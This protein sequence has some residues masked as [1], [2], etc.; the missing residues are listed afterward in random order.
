MNEPSLIYIVEDSPSA[1]KALVTFL[2]ASGYLTQSHNNGELLLTALEQSQKNASGL[3]DLILMD[4]LLPGI[5]GVELI[6]IIKSDQSLPFIPIIMITSSQVLDDRINSLQTGADDFLT[7]PFNRAELLARVRSL[8]RLKAA[9]DE[10]TRLVAGIKETYEQLRATQKELLKMETTKAQ[11]EAM[12]STAGAICH[13]MSQPLTSALI[14][15]Q[16]MYQDVRDSNQK[17]ELMLIEKCLLEARLILDKLRTLTRYETK[18]YVGN[19]VILD[20][21]KSTNK[22]QLIGRDL[23]NFLKDR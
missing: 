9:Y 23:D 10:Q 11:S 4:N 1:T 22:D 21:E 8:L 13:E 2:N 20:L 17:S 3:P 5:S 12:M 19:Q 18:A 16:I 15:L 6:K 14:S 7:K